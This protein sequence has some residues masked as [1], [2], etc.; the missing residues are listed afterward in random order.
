MGVGVGFVRGGAVWGLPS[1]GSGWGGLVLGVRLAPTGLMMC[2]RVWLRRRGLIP[3]GIRGA[4]P[5]RGAGR[6]R[7]AMVFVTLS[8]VF[9]VP[10]HV[11]SR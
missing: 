2:V 6:R 3:Q 4:M 11:V 8:F 10:G 5:L 9:L 1:L 7:S